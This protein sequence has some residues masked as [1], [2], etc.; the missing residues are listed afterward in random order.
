MSVGK[1]PLSVS[2]L[3]LAAAAQQRRRQLEDVDR[4]GVRDRDLARRGAD[5]R[6]DRIARPAREMEPAGVEPAA[7]QP[8]APLRRDE[9]RRCW[10]AR[11]AAARRA[12]C[13]RNRARRPA[14]RTCSRHGESGQSRSRRSRSARSMAGRIAPS[15]A[16]AKRGV[17]D[18]HGWP[19]HPRTRFTSVRFSLRGGFCPDEPDRRHLPPLVTPDLIRGLGKPGE[20]GACGP[21]PRIESG[22]TSGGPRCC[23][24]WA[25]MAGTPAYGA[26]ASHG[27]KRPSARATAACLA[28][29]VAKK[30]PPGRGEAWSAA[31]TCHRSAPRK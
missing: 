5:Q 16:G 17:G 9:R 8:P 1:L 19:E 13:R 28:S 7:D 26:T 10:R 12:S 6:R 11:S 18:R 15:R 24:S 4:G 25:R 20:R 21:G 14:A 30:R 27:S 31:A 3:R 22:V 29:S 23:R 2:T